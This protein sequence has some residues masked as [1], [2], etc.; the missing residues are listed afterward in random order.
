MAENVLVRAQ[1]KGT[2]EAISRYAGLMGQLVLNTSTGRMHI[3]SGTAG[4]STVLANFADVEPKADKSY[5]DQELAKKQNSGNYATADSVTTL[6]Q[7]IAQYPSASNGSFTGT[8]PFENITV[9]GT[10]EGTASSAVKLAN[11][12]SFAI[13]GAVT[14]SQISFDGTENVTLNATS[15]DG[16]KVS[17]SVSEAIKA[18][19][20][21]DGNNINATYRKVADKI[22]LSDLN[23]TDFGMVGD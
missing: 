8:T 10:I 23:V 13:T 15:V 21:S 12:R 16:T 1:I 5:V 2:S 19:Q 14:A 11:A 18:T 4:T 7:A 20:D 22:T 17:G 3:L 9:S 6:S